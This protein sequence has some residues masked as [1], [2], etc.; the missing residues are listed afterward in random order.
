MT[1]AVEQ[2]MT[3]VVSQLEAERAELLERLARLDRSL[4]IQ[5]AA[6]AD[7]RGEDAPIPPAGGP[8]R[9]DNARSRL[10]QRVLA[11]AK[12]P[13]GRTSIQAGLEGLGHAAE[14]DD[15]SSTLTYLRR[16]G[17]VVRPG[18]GTWSLTSV[19]S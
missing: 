15:I 4:S 11:D 19:G 1:R 18:R 8:S 12:E 16:A 2:G 17:L 10:V 14:L 3:K 6:L 9:L 7:L 13:L 5:R